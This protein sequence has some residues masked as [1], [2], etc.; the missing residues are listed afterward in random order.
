MRGRN[1]A[2]MTIWKSNTSAWVCKASVQL[3]GG[4][5]FAPSGLWLLRLIAR[6]LPLKPSRNRVPGSLERLV[7][8]EY[9]VHRASD[10]SRRRPFTAFCSLPPQW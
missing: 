8:R 4:M 3:L 5:V 2:W 1:T 6:P 10:S 9:R 7:V